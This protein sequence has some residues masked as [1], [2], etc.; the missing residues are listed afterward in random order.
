[1][2]LVGVGQAF[3]VQVV[4]AYVVDGFVVD[5]EGA[6]GVLQG[7]VRIQDGIVRIDDGGR[8]L[9]SRIDGELQLGLLAVVNRMAFYQ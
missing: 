7:G 5:H 4:T 2:L 6:V 9:R 1:M 8:D 3:N